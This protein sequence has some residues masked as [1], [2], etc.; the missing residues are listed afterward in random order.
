ME[1]QYKKYQQI[2][3]KITKD[4]EKADDLLHDV[5]IQLGNNEKY[6]S[7]PIKEQTYFFVRA[8]QNQFYSNNSAFQRTYQKYKFVEFNDK[9]ETQDE[10]YYET[11]SIEWLNE[12]LELELKNNQNFWYN[13]GIFKMYL[14]YKKITLIHQKTQ[15][16]KYSLR[17]TILEMKLWA[18]QKW[19]DYQ[20][21]RD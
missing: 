5:L 16:P 1:E 11:P 8:I 10:L 20:N 2:V 17:R 21:G 3:K 18:R 7:L 14:E 9:L 13:Y 4:S 19:I 15:I 6:L 12:M